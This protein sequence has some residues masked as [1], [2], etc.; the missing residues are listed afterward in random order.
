MSSPAQGCRGYSFR[1]MR[2]FAHCPS[3]SFIE[4]PATAIPV[5]AA[6]IGSTTMHRTFVRD[7][8]VVRAAW[9]VPNA[10][11]MHKLAGFST[12]ERRSEVRFWAPPAGWPHGCI[13]VRGQTCG[14]KLHSLLTFPAGDMPS[15]RNEEVGAMRSCAVPTRYPTATQ[16]HAFAVLGSM[17][18]CR[19]CVQ[20]R[21]L[22]S[23]SAVQA[24][25]RRALVPKP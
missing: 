21:L 18:L 20:P 6:L 4:A 17:P 3:L 19:K 9:L 25:L 1:K 10:R 5:L 12:R 23:L 22:N 14:S 2:F 7:N 16:A 13:A 11:A 8:A 15:N 24:S